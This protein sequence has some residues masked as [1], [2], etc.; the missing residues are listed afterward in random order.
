MM[1]V[2]LIDSK[3]AKEERE[4]RGSLE[5]AVAVGGWGTAAPGA[6]G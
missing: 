1:R 6:T 5:F 2:E 4:E 3:G